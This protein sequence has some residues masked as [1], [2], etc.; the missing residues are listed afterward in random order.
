MD[1]WLRGG[2][3]SGD[4]YFSSDE[5]QVVGPAYI[6][7]YLLE[8]KL[9]VN[10]RVI[11]DNKLIRELE[12]NSAQELVDKVNTSEPCLSDYNATKNNILFRW[13]FG[14]GRKSNLAQDVAFFV[15]YL[16]YAFEKESNLD[17]VINNIRNSIYLNNGVYSKFRWVTDYLLASCE[18]H[19]ERGCEIEG[20]MLMKKYLE[21]KK[22]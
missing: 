15:D 7:A 13:N 2:V 5:S 8:E 4:A 22:L 9:A 10:P 21:I 6:N 19:M 14:N 12:L 16:V 18:Y 17:L 11:L 1:I 20:G 3:S